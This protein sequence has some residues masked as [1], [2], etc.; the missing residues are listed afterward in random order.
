MKLVSPEYRKV[1]EAEHAAGP[2]GTMSLQLAPRVAELMALHGAKTVLDYGA[3]YGNLAT[4]LGNIAPHVTVIPYEPGRPEWAAIPEPVEFVACID[5]LEHVEP[6]LVNNVLD[7]LRRVTLKTGLFN[8]S[9]RPARRV[10][11]NGW[12]AHISLFTAEDWMTRIRSRF[13]VLE[14]QHNPDPEEITVVVAR[15]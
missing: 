8:I 9:L 15:K 10:L 5:V 11:N 1:L 7:D 13:N 3:G 14:L 6:E 12:N 2:W 4:S